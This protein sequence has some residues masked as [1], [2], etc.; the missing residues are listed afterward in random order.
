[1]SGGEEAKAPGGRG[2]FIRLSAGGTAG[3]AL[4]SGLGAIEAAF[5]PAA[6]RAREELDRQHE[7]VAPAPSPGDR[8]LEE[9]RIVI[10]MPN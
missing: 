5:N 1:M 7:L 4:S 10:V 6:G 8:I 3:A 2:V 9:G